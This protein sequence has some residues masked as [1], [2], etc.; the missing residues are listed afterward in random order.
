M[1][2]P[3]ATVRA[4]RTTIDV[5]GRLVVLR[6]LRDEL[7]FGPGQELELSAVDGRLEVELPATEMRLEEHDG[8]PRGGHRHPLADT[9]RRTGAREPRADP[10]MIPDSSALAAAIAPCTSTT[11]GR[12]AR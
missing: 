8:D 3:M 10:A 1:A 7:G 11:I 5:A 6:R 9:D 12:A 4:M 2:E